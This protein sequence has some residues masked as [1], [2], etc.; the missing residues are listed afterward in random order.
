[1]LSSLFGAGTYFILTSTNEN[2]KSA[3]LFWFL[4]ADIL[5]LFF[6]IYITV[7]QIVRILKYKKRQTSNGNRFQRQIITLFSCVTIIP[8]TCVFL[9]AVLFFNMGIE[10]LFKAPVKAII[11]NANQVAEIYIKETRSALENY[12]YV[13]GM[14]LSGVMNDIMANDKEIEKILSDETSGLGIDAIVFQEIKDDK[15]VIIAKSP[16]TLSLQFEDM[17]QEAFFLDNGDVLSW[18]AKQFAI[19]VNVLDRD[20][21]IYLVVSKNIDQ[22]I[23]NHKHKIRNAVHEYTSLATQRTGLKIT[24]MT[25]FS[26]III[27]LLAIVILTGILFANR[28]MKPIN[29]LIYA[30]KNISLGKYNTPIVAPKFK[31]EL[32]ILISSFNIMVTKLGEQRKELA[33]SNKQNAW[34]DIARKIAHEIKNPLTPIQLSAERLKRKYNNQITTDREVFVTCIDTII[35]QVSCIGSLV[36]EFSDFAR[37]PAPKLE[38]IDLIQLIRETVLLQSNSH[39]HINFHVNLNNITNCF[40][41]ID[42]SQIT[43]VMMNLLQNAVNAITENKDGGNIYM[44]LQKERET[45]IIICEDDG[46]GFSPNALEH[47][48]DPYFTTRESGNGLGLAVVYKIII[49]HGGQIELS[50]SKISG[51]ASVKIILPYHL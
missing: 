37:M 15:R 39:K 43:Q 9:F 14:Q 47:A 32:D 50:N 48:L 21:G 23:L 28:M 27:L 7:R 41:Y 3:S 31:N 44:A 20:S 34:R 24:F 6:L 11:E 25:F 5:L 40:C 22:N 35:R 1:M 13:V 2:L 46:P 19:A 17:P 18:E 42:P 30:A 51:G 45:C 29:S 26:S 49:E 10:S 12:A 4:Y 36:K 16:F 33:I 8:A 38:N